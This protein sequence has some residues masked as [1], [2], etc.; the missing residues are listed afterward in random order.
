MERG[1]WQA[2]VHGVSKSQT[3]LSDWAQHSTSHRLFLKDVQKLNEDKADVFS[4]TFSSN[5]PERFPRPA[6]Q[7][8]QWRLEKQQQNRVG[9]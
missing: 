6:L 7:T 8:K 2:T 1:A 5:K 3:R 9:V 4:I